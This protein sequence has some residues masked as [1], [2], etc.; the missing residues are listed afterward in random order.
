M[1]YKKIDEPPVCHY[2]SNEPTLASQFEWSVNTY[3]VTVNKDQS[4]L[5]S[6]L[7]TRHWK[8]VQGLKVQKREN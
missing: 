8:D 2:G 3:N 6:V 7:L 4:G 1:K 5:K